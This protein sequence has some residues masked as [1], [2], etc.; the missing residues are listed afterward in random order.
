[1][2]LKSSLLK[3]LTANFISLLAGVINGFLVPKFL[4]IG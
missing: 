4:E 2:D 1:M 3:V